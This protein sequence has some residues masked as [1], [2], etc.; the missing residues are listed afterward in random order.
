MST[1]MV[2]NLIHKKYKILKTVKILYEILTEITTNYYKSKDPPIRPHI[3]CIIKSSYIL[4][5][6]RRLCHLNAP[7]NFI[8]NIFFLR[9]DSA[10]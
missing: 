2:K 9:N 8:Q 4:Q 5:F 7:S 3:K 10:I 6:S 1:N